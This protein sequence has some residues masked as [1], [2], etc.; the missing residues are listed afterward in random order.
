MIEEMICAF[1]SPGNVSV[2][3]IIALPSRDL[4]AADTGCEQRKVAARVFCAF[5]RSELV[6]CG[7]RLVHE[8]SAVSYNRTHARTMPMLNWEH[9]SITIRFCSNTDA[10]SQ[11]VRAKYGHGVPGCG[12]KLSIKADEPS[13]PMLVTVG[14][15]RSLIV[16]HRNSRMWYVDCDSVQVSKHRLLT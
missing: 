3:L 15:A 12:R 6:G 11:I 8:V 16:V 13:E 4:T 2:I 1:D 5:G 7:V 14:K 9:L 10:E